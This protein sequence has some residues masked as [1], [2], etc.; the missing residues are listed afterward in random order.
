[1]K[2]VQ[3]IN[4][5]LKLIAIDSPSG[6]EKNISQFVFQYLKNLQLSPKVDKN[7]Q[8]YCSINKNS[9][10][11][12]L[13][14]CAHLDTVE[15]GRGI[16]PV[17]KND[18]IVS[19][20][21]TILGADNKVAV[22]SILQAIKELRN[23]KINVELVFSVREETDGGIKEF[24]YQ[25]LRSK[26]GFVFDLTDETMEKV[27]L[28]APYIDD[29]L[30]QFYGKLSHASRPEQGVNVLTHFL[31]CFSRL[32]LGRVN[33]ETTFNLGIISGGKATNS[34]P[35]YLEI[36]GDLRSLNEKKFFSFK[37]KI[38]EKID[39]YSKKTKVKVDIKWLPYCYGYRIKANDDYYLRLKKIYCEKF[40][41][42]LKPI[43]STGGSDASFLNSIGI[44]TFCLGDGAVDSHSLQERVK[45]SNL[46]RLKEIIKA[47][48][49]YFT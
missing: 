3:I 49:K 45:I 18:Y 21:K 25:K 44:K 39:F 35:D 19:S 36:K 23:E 6:E 8:I 40:N 15:P 9:S 22:A 28:K 26:V 12:S 2:G 46:I 30:F 20:G 41:L 32:P 33:K 27:I 38:E 10:K 31:D 29:F 11:R 37:K 47:L 24:N 7:N 13:L 4:L 14:F 5:F 1:M 42:K 48:I 34:I 43:I 16:K 17:I